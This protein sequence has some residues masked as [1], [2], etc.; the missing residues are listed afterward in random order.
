MHGLLGKEVS[1]MDWD[2]DE[3]MRTREDLRLK[4]K[5][6]NFHGVVVCKPVKYKSNLPWSG[7]LHLAFWGLKAIK[8]KRAPTKDEVKLWIESEICW[9][10]KDIELLG[11]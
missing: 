8:K 7:N 5:G 6:K 1:V 10:E 9:A 2:K 3:G 11:C 4:D